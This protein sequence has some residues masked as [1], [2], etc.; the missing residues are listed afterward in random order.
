L[1]FKN[2]VLGASNKALSF[3]IPFTIHFYN[4]M[5]Y[6]TTR[7]ILFVHWPYRRVGNLSKISKRAN[8]RHSQIL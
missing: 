6:T 2:L 7:A 8:K 5:L 1:Q 3:N 4:E